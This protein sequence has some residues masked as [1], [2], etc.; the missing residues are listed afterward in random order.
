MMDAKE[1]TTTNILKLKA[2]LEEAN[3]IC[4]SMWQIAERDGKDTNWE[5]LRVQLRKALDNQHSIL[6]H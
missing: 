5:A 3:Q 2:A 1:Y 6:H 4:R